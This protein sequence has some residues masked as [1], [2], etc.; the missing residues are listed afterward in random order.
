MKDI[1]AH[2]WYIIGLSIGILN[3][4]LWGVVYFLPI[5]GKRIQRPIYKEENKDLIIETIL[6]MLLN[7]DEYYFNEIKNIRT[8]G[9]CGFIFKLR[10]V[11]KITSDQEII[12]TD[13]LDYNDPKK[14][15]KFYSKHSEISGYY[16]PSKDIEIRRKWLIYQ[17]NLLTNTYQD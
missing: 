1:I 8:K 12:M 3:L 9:L 5:I 11:D 4:L 13:Y 6:I 2:Y 7:L 17:L 10:I 14:G 15:Y 16:W